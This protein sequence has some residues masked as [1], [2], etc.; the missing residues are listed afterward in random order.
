MVA[1]GAVVISAVTSVVA[2][3]GTVVRGVTLVTSVVAVTAIVVRGVISGIGVRAATGAMTAM[4]ASVTTAARG[5]TPGIAA[6]AATGG[7]T[8]TV[9]SEGNATA[10]SGA[11]GIGIALRGRRTPMTCTPVRSSRRVPSGRSG[12]GRPDRRSP[13]T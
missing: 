2:A 10:D 11:I 8:V 12:N 3:T 4:A 9:G 13:T 5:V 6:R 1:S 7:T